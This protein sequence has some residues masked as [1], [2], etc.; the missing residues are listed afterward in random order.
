MVFAMA[1]NRIYQNFSALEFNPR[2]LFNTM[3]R[4]VTSLWWGCYRKSN[5]TKVVK[6]NKK[7]RMSRNNK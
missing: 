2:Q 4:S 1:S 6:F 7:I 3:I 5:T